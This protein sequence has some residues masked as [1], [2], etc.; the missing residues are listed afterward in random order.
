[1]ELSR[2]KLVTLLLLLLAGMSCQPEKPDAKY[3]WNVYKGDNESSSYSALD[4]INRSNVSQLEVAWTLTFSD[5]PAGVSYG[6]YECNPII[7]DH[8]LYATSSRSWL[9]A[10][11]A[12]NGEEIWSFDPFEGERGGGMKRGVSYWYDGVGDERILFTAGN[13]L[14]AVDARTGKPIP[15]FGLGGKVDLNE[16]LGVDPDSVWVI[17]TS[18]GI[19]YKD[20]LILGS[21]VSESYDAAPGH[22]RAFDTRTGAVKWI[23][24]TIPQPGEPGY[25]TWPEH[26]WRY[27]G[28]ANNWGGMSLDEDRG[29]VYIP[30]G[31]PTYD[32]YG[33]NRKGKNLYGN[34]LIALDARS[35]ELRWY[36]QTVHHD[37]WDY[38]LPAPPTLVDLQ[39]DG[40]VVPAVTLVSKTGFLYV[41]DRVSGA[42][43][44]PIEERFVPPSYIHDE[45]I[46]PT[47]PFPLKPEPF[48]RQRMT[49]NDVDD[50]ITYE[51]QSA[52]KQRLQ[53]L[54]FEGLFTPPDQR[55]A[56]M[57]PGT[58]GGAEWGGTAVEPTSGVLYI[59]SNESPEIMTLQ[60]QNQSNIKSDQTLYD[61]GAKYYLNHCAICHGGDRKGQIPLNP[62]LLDLE[63]RMTESAALTVIRAGIRRM[64][65]FSH[66]TKTQGEAIIAYL[67]NNTGNQ[68]VD[69][70]V[71]AETDNPGY[72][73][74]TAYSFFRDPDGYPAI[75]PPW[76]TLNAIDLH[77]GA[78]IWRVPLGNY[79]ER[80]KSGGPETGTEN[81]GGP[82]V[83]AGGLVFIAATRDQAFR[84][85]DKD[86][87]LVQ[88]STTLPGGGYATPATYVCD[89]KQYIIISVSGTES[90]PGGSLMAFGLPEL[91]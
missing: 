88:W 2:S 16:G 64:P 90:E 51:A 65:S 33:A 13:H 48:A 20:L 37:L 39:I 72:R 47:Q 41:F 6:K 91:Q 44:F 61:F 45:E 7:I 40:R 25:E 38:D 60:N 70:D 11:D 26:A 76:G 4:Q 36:F 56:L 23:F 82:I 31:S 77:T 86:T 8:V 24:H 29:I 73:N 67:F 10:V 22:I 89:D 27:T 66:I 5:V 75:K 53:E 14:L 59:N 12:C 9:Y 35:G 18:P 71:R 62:A 84:A 85:F 34:C 43:L 58:R 87:G 1:M 78:Y 42:S 49:G 81:W 15:T 52:V 68:I 19:V 28:G 3:L 69:T 83:T 57:I 46:W 80:Q 74:I 21:E 63:K 50:N 30:L 32:F 55:G 17:P 79:P 54:R